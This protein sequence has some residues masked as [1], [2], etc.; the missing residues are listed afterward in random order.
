MVRRIFKIGNTTLIEAQKLIENINP[1]LLMKSFTKLLLFLCCCAIQGLSAQESAD[2]PTPDSLRHTNRSTMSAADP[3]QGYIF[4][5]SCSNRLGQQT[6]DVNS[7]IRNI[8]TPADKYT[9]TLNVQIPVWSLSTNSG[10]IPVSLYY[11]ASGIK[12]DDI[13]SIVGLGWGLSAGGKIT[14]VVKGQPD[15]LYQLKNTSKTE[16][17]NLA[18]FQKCNDEDWD[19]Q[20]DIYYYELPNMSGSFVSDDIGGCIPVPH[21][22]IR[23]SRGYDN[24][25]TITDTQ[26]TN[27]YFTTHETTKETYAHNDKTVTYISTWYLDRIVYINGAEVNFTYITGDNYNFKHYNYI[28]HVEYHKSSY[29]ITHIKEIPERSRDVTTTIEIQEPKYLSSIVYRDQEVKFG[30][31]AQR[32]LDL[33]NYKRLCTIDVYTA[34]SKIRT[35]AFDYYHF[36]NGSLKLR[37]IDE[38]PTAT[39]T[40]PICDFEYYEDEVLYARDYYGFDHWGYRNSDVSIPSKC[41]IIPYETVVNTSEF[42]AS[43]LPVLKYTRAQSL[44]KILYPNG[45]SKEF[46]YELHNGLNQKTNTQELAGGLRIKEIIEKENTNAVPAVYKYEYEGGVIYDSQ[47]AYCTQYWDLLFIERNGQSDSPSGVNHFYDISSRCINNTQDFYGA[48]VIYSSVKEYMPNGSYIEYDYVPY[49]QYKDIDPEDYVVAENGA[50]YYSKELSGRTPKTIRSWGR[51]L[52]KDQKAYSQQGTLLEHQSFEYKFDTINEIRVPSYK[53]ICD[54]F[55]YFY[56]S[57][58]KPDFLREDH[59]L[60]KYEWISCPIMMTKSIVQRTKYT[61]P[62]TTEYVYNERYLPELIVTREC[63]GSRIIQ[64]L[65][66]AEVDDEDEALSLLCGSFVASPIERVTYKDGYVIDAELNLYKYNEL[67][68]FST[69]V[70]AKKLSFKKQ[71]KVDSLAFTPWWAQRPTLYDSRYHVIRSYDEYNVYGDLL[72]YHEANGIQHSLVYGSGSS[73]IANVDNA[74][75]STNKNKNNNQVYFDD[76]ETN[77]T[78]DANAKSGK[79]VMSIV[80]NSRYMFDLTDLEIGSYIVT[81]WYKTSSDAAWKKQRQTLEITSLSKFMIQIPISIISDAI[82][83]DDLSVLPQNATLTS[84]VTVTGLGTISETDERG[85]TTYYEYNALGLPTRVFDNDRTVIKKYEYDPLIF[86]FQ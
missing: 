58:N 42:G 2:L 17:W 57:T 24:G 37:G 3:D 61:L 66:Y 81:Y 27:Y 16:L 14:R 9:G 40:R 4:D 44:K 31:D 75:H 60:G 68:P 20:W 21:Q 18:L 71:E 25:F 45:G 85:R 50:E 83:I 49:D 6:P 51:N 34:A 77:G 29:R 82:A 76:F 80:P 12:N 38:K 72:S 41:P 7:M 22:N 53:M 56:E 55:G 13:A 15:D 33:P 47:F 1:L 54:F 28:T 73:P 48:S 46:I 63:D 23:I 78:I 64:K 86:N 5:M 30:Y 84:A 74:Y 35:F 19:T 11:T 62:Q 26:G 52:L 70:P 69:A 10:E 67:K 32:A 43:R 65:T 79:K 39:L 8:I 59:A 36:P